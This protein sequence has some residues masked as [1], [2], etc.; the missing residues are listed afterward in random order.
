MIVTRTLPLDA[1]LKGMNALGLREMLCKYPCVVS[2]IFPAVQ[3]AVVSADL[4]VHKVTLA[5]GEVTDNELGEKAWKWFQRFLEESE[6]R[7]GKW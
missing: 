3:D 6:N 2:K 4:F 1:V 5:D 7:K